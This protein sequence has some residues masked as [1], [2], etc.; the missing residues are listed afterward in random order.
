[1]T[2]SD[3]TERNRAEAT[4]RP[5]HDGLERR[6]QERTAELSAANLR[7]EA[8][9]A[10]R[11]QAEGERERLLAQLEAE[12]A[13]LA[14]VLQQLPSGVI[15]A[16]APSGR[17]LHYNEEAARFLRHPLIPSAAVHGAAHDCVIHPDGRPYL[18]EE[19]S[20]ARA[21]R[22]EVVK[23]ENL[24]CSHAD[25]GVSYL[26]VTSAPVRDAS[27]RI[28]AAVSTLH[29]VSER[30]RAEVKRAEL[31]R[32]LVTL[33]EEE[34]YR[35]ARELH[36]QMG[37]HLAA[38]LL[39]LEALK[40]HTQD[41]PV[42]VEAL[43]RLREL[44]NQMGQD[45]HRIALE[46]R[47]TALDDWGLQT[48]LTNYVA[49]WSRRSRILAQLYCTGMDR[50]RL[51]AAV[52]TALYRVAQEGL[53][54]VLKHAQASRVSVIVERSDDHVLAIVEDNGRGF[55]VEA[56][57]GEPDARHRLGL[58]G[59]E[60]RVTQLGG[61]LEIESSPGG[62]TSLFIRMPLSGEGKAD[63]G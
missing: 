51:P 14:A 40:G 36:D 9:F 17:I 38:F 50:H 57:L 26:C 55:E 33:Q 60:E 32:R 16:E 13:R 27:G 3:V 30:R 56:V 63:H 34:R 25:S 20:I 7:L 48:A 47:P 52:E 41:R 24:R 46:L 2:S 45:V 28:V 12:R 15:I 23:E 22:G 19:Y 29:D 44:A 11:K 42:A 62:G 10:Q 49:E 8:E 21:L 43:H 31:L 59:M 6:A 4:S 54:N 5:A 39:G 1:V 61:T 35:I 37:Q 18:P 53:T 58:L